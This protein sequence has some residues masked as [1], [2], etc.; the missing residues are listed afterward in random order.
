MDRSLFLARLLGPTFIAVALGMLINLDVYESMIAEGLR[1]GILFYLSGLLSLLAG[2]AIVNLHNRWE[3]DWR[4]IITVLG[5][6]M[7]IGGIMRIV[8]PQVALAV[9]STIYSGRTSTVVAALITGTLG[10]FLSFKG[11]IQRI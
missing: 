8:L 7:T 5:W 9:G 2:L 3:L 4:V 10:A 11:Y 6:L 1:P